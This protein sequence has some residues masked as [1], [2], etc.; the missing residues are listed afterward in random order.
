MIYVLSS[1]RCAALAVA[2]CISHIDVHTG[3]FTVVLIVLIFMLRP[4]IFLSVFSVVV[5]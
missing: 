4:S 2:S 5:S 1:F 3:R